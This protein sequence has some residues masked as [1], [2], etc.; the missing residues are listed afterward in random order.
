MAATA[1]ASHVGNGTEEHAPAPIKVGFLA[2]AARCRCPQ[3]QRFQNPGRP[4]DQLA[5]RSISRKPA[6]ARSASMM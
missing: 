1:E 3:A 2:R 5:A 4:R 6:G